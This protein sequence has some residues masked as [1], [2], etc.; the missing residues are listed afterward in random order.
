MVFSPNDWLTKM[1]SVLHSQAPGVS[2][3]GQFFVPLGYLLNSFDAALSLSILITQALSLMLMYRSALELSRNEQLVTVL[4]CLVMASAPL[5]VGMSHQYFAEPL[6]LLSVTWFVMIMSRA[7]KWDSAF[8]LS[9][10]LIATFVA[11][12]AKV[13][14]PLYCLGPGLVALWYAFKPKRSS[15]LKQDWLQTRV[16]VSLSL[17]MLVGIAT[18]AWYYQN[19]EFVIQ[20]VSIASSGPIAELYG[21]KESFFNALL[22]WLG[23]VQNA[24]FLPIVL[25]ISGLVFACGVILYCING[26]MQIEH[27]TICAAT[28]LLQILVVLAMFSLNSNRDT[29]Y[30]LPLLP[31][32]VLVIGWSV[33]Q[34]NAAIVSGLA[35]AIFSMQLVTI[36]GQAL[37]VI[38]RM[39]TISVWLL[40][41]SRN[42]TEAAVLSAI[43]SKTCIKTAAQHYW[44][45]I[46]IEKPWLN[47]NSAGYFA[48]KNLAPYNRLGCQYGSVHSFFESDPDKV[49]N[50]V[51]STQIRYYITI[52]PGSRPVPEDSYNQAI[53]RNYL[54]VLRKVQTSGLFEVEPP[55]AEDPSI[56]IFRRKK[57]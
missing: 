21:K 50:N 6:Q 16:L 56:L 34:I 30:L 32:F 44:N 17:G 20:H 31:H 45:I 54:P 57:G 48:A 25:L 51:L 33:A 3:V 14:S 28:S 9:Q 11:M 53:N 12:L 2:W 42:Q 26:S 8:I 40:P 27:F 39:S 47:A 49:W 46:G 35:V 15:S 24:Y 23:A 41:E 55:I 7:P 29:R 1:L 43:V 19:I 36:Y 13:S 10:L 52:S 18:L 38:P 4:S 37:S 5:F 22:F